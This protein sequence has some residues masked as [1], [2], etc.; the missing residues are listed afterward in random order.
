[1]PKV[2]ER[3]S[4]CCC[5]CRRTTVRH[6]PF[7]LRSARSS[8]RTGFST[9]LSRMYADRYPERQAARRCVDPTTYE[10]VSRSGHGLRQCADVF[11]TT[12]CQ[13]L[14]GGGAIRMKRHAADEG[15]RRRAMPRRSRVRARAGPAR[16]TRGAAALYAGEDGGSARRSTQR[17]GAGR[18]RRCALR[19]LHDRGRKAP[20]QRGRGIPAINCLDGPVPTPAEFPGCAVAEAAPPGAAIWLGH[21]ACGGCHLMAR[22]GHCGAAP[23]IVVIGTS[24]D[25]ATLSGGPRSCGATRI[26]A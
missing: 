20:R 19:R 16:L 26:R 9:D 6:G 21:A 15:D 12:G 17:R 3:R 14:G 11:S 25:P 22:L 10:E 13:R 5:M 1:L 7:A 8:C 24:N 2:V 18:R 23:P 4:S